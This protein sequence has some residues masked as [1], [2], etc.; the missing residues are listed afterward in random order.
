MRH[1]VAKWDLHPTFF[2]DF[3]ARKLAFPGERGGMP[4]R[5][6]HHDFMHIINRY[7]TDAAGECE[8]AELY[9]GSTPGDSFT[10]IGIALATFHLG[11]AVSPRAASGFGQS[12]R[13]PAL[14]AYTRAYFEALI[15]V[16]LPAVSIPAT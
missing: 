14:L 4:E 13:G 16:P 6:V 15:T 5:T 3:Q 12:S 2:D 11:M 7:G 1:S 10:F 9:A 8:L